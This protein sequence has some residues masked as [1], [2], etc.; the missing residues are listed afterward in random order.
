MAKQ[1]LDTSDMERD[2]LEDAV[3]IGISTS[4]PAYKLCW[5]LNTALDLN[6]AR[7]IQ[8]DIKMVKKGEVRYFSVY[9]YTD[10]VSTAEH[11][12]YKLRNDHYSLLA[13]VPRL[14]FILMVKGHSSQEGAQSLINDLRTFPDISLAQIID[15]DKLKSVMN[16]I[17]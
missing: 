6:F 14:D 9:K 10:P 5:L 12:I 2:F 15:T 3:F 1:V 8:D 17:L 11:F 16:L 4:L 13:E 7:D